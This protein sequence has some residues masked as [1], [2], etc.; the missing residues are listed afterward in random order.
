[1]E[2]ESC[3]DDLLVIVIVVIPRRLLSYYVLNTLKILRLLRLTL[4]ESDHLV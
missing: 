3:D 2:E 4:T 1:M